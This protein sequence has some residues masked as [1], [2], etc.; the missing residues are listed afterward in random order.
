[1]HEK[2]YLVRDFDGG[3]LAPLVRHEQVQRDHTDL[4]GAEGFGEDVA[5][6]DESERNNNWA[7]TNVANMV[8]QRN[9]HGGGP[10]NATLGKMLLLCT[11]A[12][13]HAH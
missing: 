5:H 9:S 8:Q 13:H 6:D 2:L 3:D 4:R 1:M 12:Q 7:C 11:C 10:S